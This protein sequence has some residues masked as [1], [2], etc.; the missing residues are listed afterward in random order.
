[1]K[2]R[3]ASGFVRTLLKIERD[4]ISGTLS[5]RAGGVTTRI[6]FNGG[7]L[8]FADGGTPGEALGRVLVDDGRISEEQFVEAIRVMTDSL[9][10]NEQ[11]RLGE[12]LVML[13]F[14]DLEDVQE[15]LSRQV[16]RKVMRCLQWDKMDLALEP[17]RSDEHHGHFPTPVLPMVL[18]GVRRFVERERMME[19]LKPWVGCY[20]TL[21]GRSPV[22][23]TKMGMSGEEIEVIQRLDGG[24]RLYELLRE[25]A[26]HP[27]DPIPLVSALVIVDLVEP[28]AEP[29]VA[30]PTV[31]ERMV[32]EPPPVRVEQQRSRAAVQPSARP[33][34]FGRVPPKPSP[35]RPLSDARAVR[36][37]PAA[38]RQEDTRD[39]PSSR[40]AVA[41]DASPLPRRGSKTGGE[42]PGAAA[43]GADPR[44]GRPTWRAEDEPRRQRPTWRDED[45]Q[46]RRRRPTWHSDAPGEDPRRE[47]PT[48]R[49]VEELPRRQ[50]G[51]HR[52]L[53]DAT[54]D[55]T[56]TTTRRAV[57]AAA[58]MPRPAPSA[59]PDKAEVDSKRSR[60][61]AEQ[62]YQRGLRLLWTER[63][64]VAESELL[65]ASR[66]MPDVAEY[67]LGAAW[68]RYRQ[69]TDGAE[70][71]ALRE[72]LHKW[73]R[74]A[75]H[76]D[77]SLAF[78]PYVAAHLELA[79]GNEA[80]ALRYF[81]VAA[82][83]NAA[84]ID[85]QRHVRL[86]EKRLER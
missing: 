26:V 72:E 44:H 79:E 47:R 75:A 33:R 6:H 27:P 59:A 60:L 12:V 81:R 57:D 38:R 7:S 2:E 15:A 80:K 17:A 5:V 68:A 78:P 74:R 58:S 20:V 19:L 64:A 50:R 46:P 41:R 55:G 1:M 86:L 42:S 52:A 66:L 16:R 45:E 71:A 23:G 85:A 67:A 56:P 28:H 53:G 24:T 37:R 69:C 21:R 9:V 25:L 43:R 29:V 54:L 13:G 61:E 36:E 22:V 83:R 30:E 4:G 65:R 34:G 51:T 11:M 76:Q 49:N 84:N 32:V 3:S 39:P 73:V 62:A 14:L 82:E 63:F 18:E 35:F 48:W 70:L 77:R 8:V 10:D 31:A 40:P